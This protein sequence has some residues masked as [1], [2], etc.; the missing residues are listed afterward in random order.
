MV[1]NAVH[2]DG[3]PLG[4]HLSEHDHNSLVFTT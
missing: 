1:V 4:D 2:T 3:Q